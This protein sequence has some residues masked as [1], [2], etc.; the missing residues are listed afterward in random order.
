[1]NS[2]T[3]IAAAV[4][5]ACAWPLAA[6]ARDTHSTHV[7]SASPAFSFSPIVT[8]HS[9]DESAP[10]LTAEETRARHTR[11]A[12]YVS[13]PN[14]QSPWS[15]NESGAVNYA[16]EMRDRAQHVAAVEQTRVAVIREN[17]RIARVERERLAQIEAERLEAERLAAAAANPAPESAT[18][19]ATAPIGSPLTR[20]MAR[21]F[22]SR[23][24]AA[25]L[26]I[27]GSR[28]ATAASAA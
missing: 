8:P 6:V 24:T 9:V 4:A 20:R 15:P 21:R 27:S 2:R 16:E 17:E 23:R 13:L 1:M 22:C 25:A 10:W 12:S 18:V 19:I 28:P 3:L 26:S 11:G 7:S 14:P 5:S